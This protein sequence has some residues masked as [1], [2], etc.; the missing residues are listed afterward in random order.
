MCKKHILVCERG[1]QEVREL[2]LDLARRDIASTVLIEGLVDK[3]TREMITSYN[4]INNLFIAEK[5]FTP[6]L[7]LYTL[8][9]LLIFKGR[10]SIFLSRKK[11]YHRLLMLKKL[12][13]CFELTKVYDH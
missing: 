13:P 3:E 5:I 2:S 1:W 12:F 4:G 9:N 11:T 8:A 7:H 6:F 10:I